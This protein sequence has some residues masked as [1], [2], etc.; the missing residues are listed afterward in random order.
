MRGN[1]GIQF[2]FFLACFLSFQFVKGQE[3]VVVPASI[4]AMGGGGASL[5]EVDV[6]ALNP[7]SASS[8][9]FTVGISYA[10]RFLLKELAA[11]D[12]LL[13]F[14]VSG[15]RVFAEFGQF[16]SSAFRENYAGIGLARKF[17]TH[18]SGG[19]QFHYFQLRMAESDRKP[20]FS[21][22]SLGLNCTS[23]NFGVGLSV[24]NPLSQ[25]MR[26]GDFSHE[27]PCVARFGVH[28]VF[29]DD[30]LVVSEITWDERAEA[31]VHAGLQYFLLE[32][33]CMRAGVQTSSPSCS[34]GL[35]FLFGHVQADFAF[36]YHEY[37]GFSPSVS[38]Y[39][40]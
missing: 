26:S 34:M 38:F 15:S 40:K 37:L 12:A 29:G 28:K 9:G 33:F 35:G 1:P 22:F 17:G 7:A 23:E 4:Q 11:G 39:F 16:G 14:P 32:R 3:A 20:G 6:L 18:F 13:V 5:P 36:S 10:N 25:Q 30:L 8:S 24:F 21:T 27:Y 19:V 31:T 2:C